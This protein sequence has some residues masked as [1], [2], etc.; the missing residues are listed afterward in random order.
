[1]DI[2]V[3]DTER[4]KCPD[5]GSVQQADIKSFVDKDGPCGWP[6]YVHF[7]LCGYTIMESEWDEIK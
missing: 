6:M 1:M 3:V 2:L 5:C 4:I 7:C